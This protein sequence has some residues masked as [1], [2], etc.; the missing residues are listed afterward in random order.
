MFFR[1]QNVLFNFG[2]TFSASRQDSISMIM[3]S[4]EMNKTWFTWI[5]RNN[6][7]LADFPLY[8]HRLKSSYKRS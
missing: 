3:S 8:V 7:M 6:I 5:Y 2:A 4:S 1:G